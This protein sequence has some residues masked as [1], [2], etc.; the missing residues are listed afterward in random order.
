[1]ALNLLTL[2]RANI[3]RTVDLAFTVPVRAVGDGTAHPA[4]L[5]MEVRVTGPRT[6]NDRSVFNVNVLVICLADA[7]TNAYGYIDL[8][9]Q[10]HD[11]LKDISITIYEEQLVGTPPIPTAVSTGYCLVQAGKIEVFDLGFVD[12]T[13]NIQQAVVT[14]DLE[15][16]T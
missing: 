13:N 2:C 1:M 5:Y 16:E 14:C 12:T 6:I 4:K 10:V 15:L 8:A 7:D 9:N 11:L 3:I